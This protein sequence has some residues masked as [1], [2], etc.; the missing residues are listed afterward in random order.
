MSGGTDWDIEEIT[1]VMLDNI[2]FME[3]QSVSKA[4]LFAPAARRWLVLR[5][6]NVSGEGRSAT[7][8]ITQVERMLQS[9]EAFIALNSGGVRYLGGNNFRG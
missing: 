8:N 1:Q 9:A 6:V 2:D 3:A 4:K 7:L 5:P